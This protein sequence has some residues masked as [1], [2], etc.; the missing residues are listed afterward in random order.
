MEPAASKRIVAAATRILDNLRITEYTHTTAVDEAAGTY[1]LDCSGLA[2]FLLRR[3]APRSL[4]QVPVEKGRG[5]PRA[6]TFHTAFSEAPTQRGKSRWQR[7]TSIFDAE[8]GDFIAWRLP[9]VPEGGST[10]H[11][12]MVMKKPVKQKDGTARVVVLDSSKDRH[13]RDSRAKGT[14]GVGVGT[15]WFAV[16]QDGRPTSY[17]WSSR[18]RRP[19]AYPIAIGRAVDA[20][21]EG[22]ADR[23]A[24]YARLAKARREQVESL[25]AQ[26]C[27]VDPTNPELPRGLRPGE[28]IRVWRHDGKA[29]ARYTVTFRDESPGAWRSIRITLAGRKRLGY[30]EPKGERLKF[31][32]H[33]QE[34]LQ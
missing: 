13:A 32:I 12:V 23:R 33:K 8:P 15:M 16:D 22:D 10:G 7:I 31:E 14:T 34:L 21:R 30:R 20:P 1:R 11:V 17:Y 3:A 9:V 19:K 26:G 25:G 18:R 2:F 29:S 27:S 4:A 24:G 28:T 6:V 5:R